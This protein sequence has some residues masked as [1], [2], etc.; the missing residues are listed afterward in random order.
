MEN[1]KPETETEKLLKDQ[2]EEM[3]R[4]NAML[5]AKD[6]RD[7]KEKKAATIKGTARY[8]GNMVT[9]VVIVFIGLVVLGMILSSR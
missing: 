3:R 8:W 7:Q 5:E 4:Q 9:C 1:E 6:Q 2:L